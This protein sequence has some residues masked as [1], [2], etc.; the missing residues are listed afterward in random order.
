MQHQQW[1]YHILIHNGPLPFCSWSLVGNSAKNIK[2]KDKID[3]LELKQSYS[4]K[5]RIMWFFNFFFNFWTDSQG[6]M[7]QRGQT[8]SDAP[9]S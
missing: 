2:N 9:T 7:G 5:Y 1:K 4:D 8:V 6:H 3:K